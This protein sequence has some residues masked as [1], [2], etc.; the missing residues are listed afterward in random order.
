MVTKRQLNEKKGRIA[1]SIATCVLRLKGYRI[2]ARRF[3][4]VVGEIDIV[5]VKKNVL[6]GVEVK[7][8]A[9]YDDALWSLTPHQQKRIMKA[10]QIF[11]IYAP[12]WASADV[13]F[14]II[15]IR[16]PWVKHLKQAW[17]E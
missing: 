16:F 10:L 1:E 17:S 15:L 7:A 5:A 2:L 13:R 4:T 6:I 8:R 3:K 14:D 11:L 9:T 12:K